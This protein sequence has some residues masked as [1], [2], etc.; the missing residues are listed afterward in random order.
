MVHPK[1]LEGCGIDS[2]KYSGFAFGIG[3]ERMAMGR[4]RFND[5][6]LIFDNVTLVNG[7]AAGSF[8]QLFRVSKDDVVIKWSTSG[9]EAEQ[10]AAMYE[11]AKVANL[12]KFFPQ[13]EI[14]CE[15]N[16]ITFVRQEKIDFSCREVD[17]RTARKFERISKTATHNIVHKMDRQ[18]KKADHGAGYRRDL[19]TMWAKM[20]IVLYGKKAC[21]A[22]S[23][24]VQE[25]GIN[26]LHRSNLGY[27]NGKPI[28]L[29]FS[30]FRR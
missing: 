13:T 16:G 5:L 22:L 20:A 17:N 24:F 18:F 11:R 1:V 2:K 12:A 6:R 8:D 25:N 10:E 21:K 14:L 4:L 26:D 30:G 23:D 19:D 15:H 9:D 28:I 3:L 27:K 7:G 29:D